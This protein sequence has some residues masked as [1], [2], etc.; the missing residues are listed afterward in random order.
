LSSSARQ[1]HLGETGAVR[2]L[3]A[4]RHQ[5]TIQQQLRED[6]DSRRLM[7][8]SL[9]LD[10]VFAEAS[11]LSRRYAARHLARSLDLL[12]VAAAHAARCTTFV[13]A[14]DRQLAVAKATGLRTVDIKRG[15]RRETR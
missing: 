4:P 14:D 7:P 10:H 15:A 12:H 11:E 8:I 2:A 13:S 1:A 3:F 6:L 5:A 9:D